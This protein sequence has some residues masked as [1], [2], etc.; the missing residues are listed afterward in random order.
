MIPPFSKASIIG[1]H[2]KWKN[3]CNSWTLWEMAQ[4]R[5]FTK[6][7]GRWAWKWV[8]V[9]WCLSIWIETLHAMRHRMAWWMHDISNVSSTGRER[10][11][12]KTQADSTP[13]FMSAPLNFNALSYREPSKWWRPIHSVRD[14]VLTWI[15]LRLIS[16]RCNVGKML[17][18]LVVFVGYWAVPIE[19]VPAEG[20]INVGLKLVLVEV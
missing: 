19:I 7:K 14:I 6:Y 16:M 11:H 2:Q 1:L 5:V 17:G 8:M 13:G 18:R 10:R 3:R 4:H 9:W 15:K 12:A 20:R